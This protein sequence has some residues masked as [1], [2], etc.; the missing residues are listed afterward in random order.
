MLRKYAVQVLRSFT[1]PAGKRGSVPVN[2]LRLTSHLA[3]GPIIVGRKDALFKTITLQIALSY[4]V[5]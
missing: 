3:L 5:P 4:S 2:D 1:H